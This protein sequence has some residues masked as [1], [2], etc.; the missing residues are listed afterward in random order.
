MLINT[1]LFRSKLS[2]RQSKIEQP[3]R[4]RR[5]PRSRPSGDR[6]QARTA[7]PRLDWKAAGVMLLLLT[8]FVALESFVPLRTAVKIGADEDFELSKAVLCVHG[9][10]L[11]TQIW[12]DQPPLYTF[13]LT[14]ILERASPSI[15]APRLL[16]VGS[17]GLLLCG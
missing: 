3:K 5:P 15:L 17:A 2:C 13:L 10:Q 4:G 12:D 1:E 8:A 14:Q 9:Y 7:F 11:Y 6:P 16:T